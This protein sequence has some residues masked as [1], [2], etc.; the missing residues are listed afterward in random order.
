MNNYD[1]IN[2]LRKVQD[3][4]KRANNVIRGIIKRLDKDV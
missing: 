3:D 4:L 2:E 1:T